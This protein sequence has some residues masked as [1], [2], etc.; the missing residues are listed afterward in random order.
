MSCQELLY[1]ERVKIRLDFLGI[2]LGR[3]K[4]VLLL[5]TVFIFFEFFADVVARGHVGGVGEG[6]VC[7]VATVHI[8]G[9]MVAYELYVDGIAISLKTPARYRQ[10]QRCG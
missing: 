10:S 7:P 5:G 9:Y 1:E 6:D 2:R 3:N 4:R 8:F